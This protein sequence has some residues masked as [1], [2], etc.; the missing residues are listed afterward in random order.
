MIAPTGSH[1]RRR[2]PSPGAPLR[3]GYVPLTDCAPL[4]VAHELG[5]FAR[6]GLSVSLSRELGWASVRDKLVQG[7]LDAAHAPCAMPF[8]LRLGVGCVPTECVA[9]LV[10]NLHGNAVTLATH[11]RKEGIT[12]G[13]TLVEWMRRQRRSR[14]LV[15]G[16]VSLHSSHAWLLRT[17][18]QRCGLDPLQELRLVVVPPPQMS[19]NLRAGHLDGFCA[20]E[21]WN[22]VAIGRGDG[23]CA[24]PSC[25]IS[26]GH[27]EKVL[28][29]LGE[30]AELRHNDVVALTAALLEACAYCACPKNQESLVTLLSRRDYAALPSGSLRPALSG[31][32]PLGANRTAHWPDFLVFQRSDSNDPT[33][34]KAGWVVQHLL[35]STARAKV[36]PVQLGR[37]FRSDLFGL[38]RERIGVAPALPLLHENTLLTV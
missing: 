14:Q 36:P 32:F 17:W 19:A 34:D 20:G 29:V 31:T 13:P 7:E 22:S 15:F 33:T 23:W 35:D 2:R 25:E 9:P 4:I 30:V 11:L 18:L 26:P 8:A 21:P 24:A 16:V 10:L 38:A 37:V 5:M 27:P 12:D 3:L 28:A 1:F 6:R